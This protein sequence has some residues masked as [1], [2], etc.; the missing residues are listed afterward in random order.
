MADLPSLA[1]INTKPRPRGSRI[2]SSVRPKDRP[3]SSRGDRSIEVGDG[4][5]HML[6]DGLHS[7]TGSNGYFRVAIPVEP[8]REKDLL[9][10]GF[11][12]PDA[13]LDT[14]EHVAGF[15]RRDLAWRGETGV[16]V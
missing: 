1:D 15:E 5:A 7:E 11:Q 12:F 8:V 4:T 14:I 10:D 16:F 6:F 13:L 9:R 2:R 3:F